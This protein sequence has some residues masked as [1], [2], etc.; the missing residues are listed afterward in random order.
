[1][2]FFRSRRGVLLAA[3][4]FLVALF[5]FRYGV[6]GTRIVKAMS[7]ALGRP[8]QVASVQ[9]RLLPRPGFD[10]K[11]F[12]ILDDPSFGA[13]PVL[14]AEEVTAWLRL[15]SLLRGRVEIS[16]LSLSEPSLNLVHRDGHWNVEALL[17]RTARIQVG[18][19][20]ATSAHRPE[21]P[22][23]EGS[24]ARINFKFGAEKKPYA[25]TDADF[26]LWQESENSWGM[27][28]KARPVRTDFNV[29]D[30]GLVRIDGTWQRA[31]T[32]RET[33]FDMQLVWERAQLGQLTKFAY[34]SDQ[35]WRGA[36]EL[37]ARLTGTPADLTVATSVKAGDFRRYDVLGGGNLRLSVQ[38]NSH[39]IAIDNRFSA[40]ACS[41]PVGDG[42]VKLAG[43]LTAS[44]PSTYDLEVSAQGVPVQSLVALARHARQ[45]VPDD[46]VATG[47]L[48]ADARFESDVHGTVWKGTGQTS[49]LQL[50]SAGGTTEIA[51]NSIPITLAAQTYKPRQPL[52]S[53]PIPQLRIVQIGPFHVSLGKQEP[54]LVKAWV[55]RSGYNLE[56]LG[57]A[58]LQRLLQVGR[59]LGMPVL[60]TNADGG[61]KIDL[62][63]AGQWSDTTS[64]RFTGKAQLTAVRAQVRGVN[65]PLQIASAG[66][67]LSADQTKV[68][69]VA[70]S[71]DGMV[72]RGSLVLPRPCAA[73]AACPVHFDFHTDEIAISRLNQILNPSVQATPWYRLLSTSGPSYLLNLNASGKLA[74]N[75]VVVGNL[76]ATQMSANV[77]LKAG[78]VHVSDLQASLLD[79]RHTGDWKAD[80]N[81]KPPEYAGSGTV[82]QF[83]LAELA[84]EMKDGWISGSATASYRL[85]G[86][87]LTV[88]DLYSSATGTVQVEASQVEMPHLSLSDELNPLQARHLTA[89]LLLN[90][91]KFEIQNGKLETAAAVYQLGGTASLARNLNVKLTRDGAPG[92]NVTGTLDKPRVSRFTPPETR[93]A[94]KP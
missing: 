61:A 64:P 66:L 16:R 92:F 18:P 75:R 32:L 58:Q 56:L 5:F 37:S 86:S 27:R 62:S 94:L 80:F 17:E 46:L 6:N 52:A 90:D 41:A 91:G 89:H 68:Q 13:E 74:A 47:Q 49:G 21:F 7:L 26:S 60:P 51:L 33:P 1:L 45:S 25:L 65:A 79:G 43:D 12:V 15:S 84:G 8:V 88:N 19:T 54:V 10:L 35:G 44:L 69:N 50:A 63:L 11:K 40:I 93:A 57:D 59:I 20:K 70:A 42:K 9:V 14:R 36:I 78:K 73:L 34:G 38:C 2:S 24:S 77:E 81:V 83:S 30:T 76:L 71:V 53:G 23:V 87:G 22:Y 3:I 67:L 31:A 28:L 55:S 48:D 82:N 39:Y 4:V 29:S 72:W 85:S